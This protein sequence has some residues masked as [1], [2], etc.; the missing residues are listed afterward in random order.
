MRIVIVLMPIRIGI[1]IEILIRI[2]IKTV[3]STTLLKRS[4]PGHPNVSSFVSTSLLTSRVG[5]CAEFIAKTKL[6]REI[7]V[8]HGPL[9]IQRNKLPRPGRSASIQFE[10]TV[11]F[12]V[13]SEG[14]GCVTC[15]F[16]NSMLQVLSSDMDLVKSRLV[17]LI[18]INPRS[19]AAV[20]T[21]IRPSPIEWEPFRAMA[22]SRTVIGH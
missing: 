2:G 16:C 12:G 18:F 3:R 22:Q 8:Y 11:I 19:V 17:L 14:I 4:G 10:T 13:S 20:L 21:K 5:E 1:N 15:C 9:H 7:A 6:R